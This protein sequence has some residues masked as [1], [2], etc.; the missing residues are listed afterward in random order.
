LAGGHFEVEPITLHIH[1][2]I[3]SRAIFASALT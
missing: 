2:R 1:E 3:N